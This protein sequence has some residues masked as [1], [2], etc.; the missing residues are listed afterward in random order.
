MVASAGSAALDLSA[1]LLQQKD[2]IERVASRFGVTGDIH[3]QDLLFDL[4]VRNVYMADPGKAV[5]AYFEDGEDSCRRFAELCQEHGQGA[6][7]TVL[8]FAAGYGRVARHAH[9]IMPDVQWTCCDIHPSAVEYARSR[10]GVEGILS[11]SRPETLDL[12]GR[13]FDVVFALSFFSHMPHAT[14]GPWLTR[15]FEAVSPNGLLIFT[16]H[17]EV[18]ARNRRRG[19]LPAEF[20]QDGHAWYQASDQRD[21]SPSDYGTSYVTFGYVYRLLEHLSGAS[22]IRYQQGWWWTHQDMYILRR[23][24]A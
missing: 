21:L 6:A 9:R 22:L 1:V 4:L 3:E 10:M 19:G 24:E 20:H 12:Q 11:S 7:R 18:S 16:T 13:R 2:R 23:R 8:E 17:G 5:D 15:L 14:F